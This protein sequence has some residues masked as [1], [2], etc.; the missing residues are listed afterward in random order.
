MT[1]LSAIRKAV[2]TDPIGGSALIDEVIYSYL[3]DQAEELRPEIEQLLGTFMSE[4]VLIAKRSLGRAYV[5]SVVEGESPSEDIQKSAEWVTGLELFIR[6]SLVKKDELT[7]SELYEFNRK[8][9]RGAGGRFRR[10][11]TTYDE[12]KRGAVATTRSMDKISPNLRGETILENKDKEGKYIV[13]GSDPKVIE[14]E[15][16]QYE[17]SNKIVN[18]MLRNFSGKSLDDIN[19]IVNLT[20]GN[21]GNLYSRSYSAKSIKNAGGFDLDPSK[22][23]NVGDIV[24]DFELEAKAGASPVVQNQVNAYNVLGNTGNAAVASLATVDPERL[25]AL[26]SSFNYGDSQRSSKLTNFFNRLSAG[27][28]VMQQVPG[29]EKYGDYARFVGAMGPQ[30]EDA[31]GPYVQQAAY[32]YR[33]TEK[34]PDL[35]LVR[36][37]NGQT[38]RAVDVAAES[39]TKMSDISDNI[40]AAA[41]DRS[42]Q[43]D[44]V[45]QAAGYQINNLSR[46]RGGA[47]T[48][49][50]LGLNVRSD[51]AAHHLLQTLPDDPFVARVSEE[52]GNI[53]PSQGVIIDA[54]GDVVSQSVGFSDDHY[55]PF[56][57]K[58]LKSLR[59]GQYVRTRQQGGLTGEDIYASIRT[60]SRMS[61]VVSSSGVYSI[62]FDPNFRG[63]RANSDKARSMYDRYL[64][65]LDA[66]DKSGLYVQDISP[67]E[68]AQLRA[69]AQSMGDKDDTIYDRFLGERRQ[70]S[71]TLDAGTIAILQDEATAQV[72]TEGFKQK[73]DRYNRRVE[74]VFDEMA[75]EKLKERASK[76]S[77]NAKGYEVALKTLQQQ[78]PYF[79]RN[80]S[81]QPLTSKQ[82]GEGFLQNLNQSG[83]LGARQSL[84]ARDSGYVNPGG[85]R[86]EQTRR[87]FNAPS[88]QAY[89][90]FKNKDYYGGDVDE[91]DEVISEP[92]TK[93]SAGNVGA[94]AAPASAFLSQVEAFSGGQK[95]KGLKAAKQLD[96]LLITIPSGAAIGVPLST[97]G[98]TW[99]DV[100]DLD[101][102]VALNYLLHPGNGGVTKPYEQTPDRVAGL[103]A[104]KEKVKEAA[105]MYLGALEST[106]VGSMGNDLDEITNKIVESG[107]QMATATSF[108]SP[109]TSSINGEDALYYSGD[110]P[111]FTEDLSM[112]SDSNSI[113]TL[114][115]SNPGVANAFNDLKSLDK[116]EVSTTLKDYFEAMKKA[117]AAHDKVL[118]VAA[119]NPG[120]QD[121]YNIDGV[122]NAAGLSKEEWS[123]VM[124]NLNDLTNYGYNSA[125]PMSQFKADVFSQRANNLQR[126]RTLLAAQG[127]M[128]VMAGGDQGPKAQAPQ[129]QL[130][131]TSKSLSKG[132]SFPRV[133]VVSKS[134]PLAKEIQLRKSLN[135][136]LVSKKQR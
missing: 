128:D 91:V 1:M 26:G 15:Q 60:G 83:K 72:D 3:S 71:Q 35:E 43:G 54:D 122:L 17:E 76:L 126:A 44:V 56:D 9:P 133:Q 134:H 67:A 13:P 102:A 8:H 93:T 65:I 94:G 51:V 4:R 119:E 92:K 25:S 62:E 73:G 46:T 47:F 61:T 14:R 107:K 96:A 112:V 118:A 97:N 57:L 41:S 100:K 120:K 22:L 53:L 16:F 82:E 2:E 89:N 86:P 21:N 74:E 23:W 135:L 78:F 116:N 10:G 50:E 101:D 31:L 124:G 129:E 84:G 81:Y 52:S 38:M 90:K 121:T 111:L 58:N 99:N 59:G 28:G 136:P 63:A 24:N 7:G 42:N 64:K 29:M 32:R 88:R 95:D 69:Q 19:V 18:S 30:A 12:E 125:S 39:R 5:A 6:D 20:D 36:S 48:P 132:Y 105:G 49:D 113:N 77:L 117:K 34:E 130:E 27:G 75:N 109:F 131:P 106:G 114:L 55:L 40:M 45:L 66:V 11:I 68:K 127:L 104:N 80:V 87:G 85:L 115:S 108:S 123:K 33:G 70:A 79:I 98:T 103:L 37:F 110:Q